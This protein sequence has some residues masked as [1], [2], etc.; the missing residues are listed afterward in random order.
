MVC[1]LFLLSDCQFSRG[2]YETFSHVHAL[3]C[4]GSQYSKEELNTRWQS[5]SFCIFGMPSIC[6][7]LFLS[8]DAPY[9]NGNYQARRD[10]IK[11]AIKE[12]DSNVILIPSEICFGVDHLEKKLQEVTGRKG[13][14]K[15]SRVG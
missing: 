2:G 7:F 12:C 5:I 10:Y 1:V 15:L 3:L 11:N 6:N 8:I 9:A 13:I 4:S 14:V